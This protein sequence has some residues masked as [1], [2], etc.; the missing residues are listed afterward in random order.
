MD[1][2][3]EDETVTEPPGIDAYGFIYML[4]Y[5]GGFRYIGKRNFFK[6]MTLPALKNGTIR[7]GAERVGKNRGGKRVYFDVIYREDF[8]DYEGSHETALKLIKKEI[9]MISLSKIN[10]T[11]MEEY[12]LFTHKAIIDEMYINRSIGGRY[13]RGKV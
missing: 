1:W 13:Y 6:K 11:Y 7:E 5:E 9:L 4:H 10:L 3:F 12:Y 8:K 2:T